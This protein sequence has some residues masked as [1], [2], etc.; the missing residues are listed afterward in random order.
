MAKTLLKSYSLDEM[1]D[2]YSGKKGSVAREDYEYE[3][4]MD[5]LGYMIKKTR[6]ERKLTQNNWENWQEFKKHRFQNWRAAPIA[7][8]LTPLLKYSKH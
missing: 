6:Q 5:V 4:R 7:L 2:K 8:P 1:E 3:L